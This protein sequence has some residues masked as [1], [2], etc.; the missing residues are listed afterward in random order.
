MALHSH[1]SGSPSFPSS[2]YTRTN[3]LRREFGLRKL[4]EPL[5]NTLSRAIIDA[6]RHPVRYDSNAAIQSLHRQ[7]PTEASLPTMPPRILSWLALMELGVTRRVVE[8]PLASISRDTRNRLLTSQ[9]AYLNSL[10]AALALQIGELAAL[11]EF[12]RLLHVQ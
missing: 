12:Q 5:P 6:W 1:L 8:A 3:P 10:Y 9:G 11:A 7:R 4:T 2:R